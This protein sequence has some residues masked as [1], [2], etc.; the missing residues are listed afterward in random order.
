MASPSKPGDRTGRD[1]L[2]EARRTSVVLGAAL[3]G[4]L[5]P[6]P[7]RGATA[8]V[9]AA[10]LAAVLALAAAV[11]R[12]TRQAAQ[13]STDAITGLPDAASFR[14][15]VADEV[16]RAGR[17]TGVLFLELRQTG[18]LGSTF[19]REA[20]EWLY[21]CFGARLRRAVRRGDGVA[22]FGGGLFTVALRN[23]S[24]RDGLDQTADRLRRELARPLPLAG[25][26]V[27]PR[28]NAAGVL[29]PADG[30]SAS[31]LLAAAETARE[32]AAA[33]PGQPL[34]SLPAAT[35][36]AA[37][38]RRHR[39]R[40]LVDAEAAGA[41]FP[42]FQPQLDVATGAVDRAEVLMRWQRSDGSVAAP[43]IFLDELRQLDALPR[44]SVAASLRW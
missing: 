29:A 28:W 34:R 44:V 24:D 3:A 25:T 13:G 4:V 39:C 41:F 19:G 32:L 35:R 15:F 5:V 20:L 27:H 6:A 37:E 17:P 22:H 30:A 7:L 14:S 16:D 38:Q 26:S 10:L 43:G 8:L 18:L 40:E 36:D 2:H 23:I 42:L 21:A 31:D 1:R 11:A 33:E 12:R 9:L